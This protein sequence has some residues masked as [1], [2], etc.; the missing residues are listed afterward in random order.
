MATL[1]AN[2]HQHIIDKNFRVLDAI[3]GPIKHSKYMTKNDLVFSELDLGLVGSI[4]CGRMDNHRLAKY[5]RYIFLDIDAY[6]Q[7][8]GSEETYYTNA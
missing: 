4:L 6:C 8:Q 3:G 1:T 2:G 7:G 5:G